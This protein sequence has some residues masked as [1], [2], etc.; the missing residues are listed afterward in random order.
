[1]QDFGGGRGRSDGYVSFKIVT[2]IATDLNAK[3]RVISCWLGG[4]G[5][6]ET[7]QV[8]GTAEEAA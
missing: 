8:R 3:V 5:S 2:S 6:G 7:F 1:M 4:E